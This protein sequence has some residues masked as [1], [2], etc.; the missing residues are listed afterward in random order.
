MTTQRTYQQPSAGDCSAAVKSAAA[1]LGYDACGITA[2]GHIDPEDRLGAWL[3]RGYHAGME[4]LARNKEIRQ[5]IRLRL[6]G[7]KS[8]VVVARNYYAGEAGETPAPQTQT[9]QCCG[10]GV[11]PARPG[12]PSRT[13]RVARYAWGRDYHKVL[14]KPLRALSG[15]IQ[16]MGEGVRCYCSIDTGPVLERAWAQRAGVGWIGKN[17]L[18]VRQ[19]LG[20]WFFLGVI[21]TTLELEPDAPAEDG[22]ASCTRCLDACPTGALVAPRVL[23][24]RR[25]ISY[26]TIEHRGPAPEEL[27]GKYGDRLFGCDACQDVCPW[28]RKARITTEAAFQPEAGCASIDLDELLDMDEEA[29]NRRFA[30]SP[31]RRATWAG[32]R[33]TAGLLLLARKRFGKTS[34][35]ASGLEREPIPPTSSDA[36]PSDD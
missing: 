12:D 34:R 4:W 19:D 28:N 9:R 11:S 31:I 21:A 23:D 10:A 6:P 36:L 26:L 14:A 18:V 2:A 16:E 24:A 20:S 27:A 7:A 30:G 17:G 25:C 22:C 1:G 5:D 35:D 32:I 33:R 15:R 13:G 29:F 8:V 3:G